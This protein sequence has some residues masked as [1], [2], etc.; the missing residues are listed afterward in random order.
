M[1]ATSN[2]AMKRLNEN[3]MTKRR[4]DEITILLK[5][6][7]MSLPRC[8]VVSFVLIIFCIF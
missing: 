5:K 2:P 6:S 1:M 3:E 8:L 7:V 4:N